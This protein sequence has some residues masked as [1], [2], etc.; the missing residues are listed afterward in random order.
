YDQPLPPPKEV[1]QKLKRL[2][3][4]S[5]QEWQEKYGDA[6]KK[7][8]LGYHF[9]KHIKQV[10][11]QDIR[12]RTQAERKREEERQRR[13]ENINKVKVK[14]VEEEMAGIFSLFLT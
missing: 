12:A 2:A 13:L 1:A 9:L 8:S 4:K 6:Y 5:V 11:F 14:R 10:D 7:L 3:I